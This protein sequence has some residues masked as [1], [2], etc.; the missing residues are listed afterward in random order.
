MEANILCRVP[1]FALFLEYN[2]HI[3]WP[4]NDGNF[5]L[6]NVVPEKSSN[7]CTKKYLQVGPRYGKKGESIGGWGHQK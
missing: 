5:Q 3:M 7:F 4:Q 6:L 2:E 1:M